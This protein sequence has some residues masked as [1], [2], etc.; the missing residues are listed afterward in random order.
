M[1]VHQSRVTCGFGQTVGPAC[2]PPV[3]GT[4]SPDSP[5]AGGGLAG[6]AV[7]RIAAFCLPFGP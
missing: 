1:T 5:H 7:S 2:A 4:V 6:N 3:A